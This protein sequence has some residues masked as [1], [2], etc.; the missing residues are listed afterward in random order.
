MKLTDVP[1]WLWAKSHKGGLLWHSTYSL[2]YV[3]TEP[4]TEPELTGPGELAML[5]SLAGVEWSTAEAAK[6]LALVH[7][8]A[9]CGG[10]GEVW[11]EHC[12]C[13]GYITCAKADCEGHHCDVCSGDG[14][15]GCVCFYEQ[16]ASAVAFC[17]VEFASQYLWPLRLVLKDPGPARYALIRRPKAEDGPLLWALAVQAPNGS[18]F[19]LAQLAE[20]KPGEERVTRMVSL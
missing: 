5:E 14:R 20:V 3:P 4:S 15:E 17:G 7:G 2:V 12:A 13:K 1:S 8:C 10:R 9:I 11:C 6:L 19:V 18:T 16:R